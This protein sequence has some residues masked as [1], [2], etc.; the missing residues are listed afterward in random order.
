MRVVKFCVC[1]PLA[2][3]ALVRA[4]LVVSTQ[5]GCDRDNNS[6]FSDGQTKGIIMRVSRSASEG[7]VLRGK[8][9]IRSRFARVVHDRMMDDIRSRDADHTHVRCSTSV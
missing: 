4:C 2:L 9:Q 8:S 1:C 5:A 3:L 6:C 7:S